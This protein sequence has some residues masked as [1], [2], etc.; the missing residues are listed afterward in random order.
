MLIFDLDGV[1]VDPLSAKADQDVVRS[2]ADELLQNR[3]E[4]VITGRNFEWVGEKFLPT[5]G[6]LVLP[7]EMANLYIVAEKSGVTAE[8]QD[9]QW[10]VTIDDRLIPPHEFK[11]KAQGL[12]TVDRGGWTLGDTMFWDAGKQTMVSIEKKPSVTLEEFK[13]PQQILKQE[14]NNLLKAEGLLKEFHTDDTT[15]ATDV[16]HVNATKYSGGKA[17]LGWLAERGVS[18]QSFVVFGDSDSDRKI[19]EAFSNHGHKTTFVFVGNP[20]ALEANQ[21]E[22]Y[23]TV[24]TGGGYS[25][26]TAA[27][28]KNLKTN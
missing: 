9:G 20:E 25:K 1:V 19:A 14:L 5:L 13:T 2:M 12:L 16:E 26:D 22:G 15:I 18:P 17:V 27:Y 23:E 6:K 24:I 3:P 11:D 7:A 4:A 8:T 10:R 28:L 21:D